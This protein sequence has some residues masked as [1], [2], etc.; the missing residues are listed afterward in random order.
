MNAEAPLAAQIVGVRVILK[1][2]LLVELLLQ[3]QGDQ[4]L[5]RLTAILATIG[6]WSAIPCAPVAS[7]GRS[8]L[9]SAPFAQIHPGR[10][11]DSNRIEA[12]VLKEVLV[13]RRE[14]RVHHHLWNIVIPHHA[15]LLALGVE[16]IADQL[17]LEIDSLRCVLSLSEIISLTLPWA[18]LMTAPS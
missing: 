3:V 14:K 6:P 9:R 5:L 15:P 16:Q 13:F 17:R 12:A 10:A 4:D 8:A 2:L 18:T 7:S 11:G 1:Y